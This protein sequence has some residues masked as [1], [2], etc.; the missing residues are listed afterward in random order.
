[1][2]TT[3]PGYS[4]AVSAVH[5]RW[6]RHGDAAGSHAHRRRHRARAQNTYSQG[7]TAAGATMVYRLGL[8]SGKYLRDSNLILSQ[9][10]CSEYW[11]KSKLRLKYFRECQPLVWAMRLH[12]QKVKYFIT[13]GEYSWMIWNKIL[14]LHKNYVYTIDTDLGL[15]INWTL[16]ISYRVTWFRKW[17]KLWS[18]GNR[19][20]PLCLYFIPYLLN[21]AQHKQ[22][23]ITVSVPHNP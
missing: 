17:S 7:Q 3:G 18:V 13:V 19:L 10:N 9:S 20:F 1:M 4:A 5:R 11:L 22:T 15:P 2:Q 23:L 16:Y 12:K 21:R 6:R 8:S 14:M